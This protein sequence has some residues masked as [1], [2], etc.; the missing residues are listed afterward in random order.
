MFQRFGVHCNR[1][2]PESHS[3]ILDT[4]AKVH[5][6]MRIRKNSF[7]ECL[8]ANLLSSLNAEVRRKM[9]SNFASVF[10]GYKMLRKEHT[11][12]IGFQNWRQLRFF[13]FFSN[14]KNDQVTDD[15]MGRACRTHWGRRGMHI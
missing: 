10:Q 15:E 9:Y 5:Y 6:E 14:V 8:S 13:V 3:Y 7:W 2:V 12:Q 4:K 11:L 1:Q